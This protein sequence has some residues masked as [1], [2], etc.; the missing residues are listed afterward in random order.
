MVGGVL[1]GF[2]NY[3]KNDVTLWRVGIVALA[4][5]TGILPVLVF[6]FA[7]WFVMPDKDDVEYDI[8][9]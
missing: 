2:S 8:M 6:Y 3:F 7:A 1:A 4:L 5:L 9:N